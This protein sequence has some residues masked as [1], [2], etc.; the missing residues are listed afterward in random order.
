MS[1]AEPRKAKT[2]FEVEISSGGRAHDEGPSRG[3]Q[4]EQSRSLSPARAAA[5]E[6]ARR[7]NWIIALTCAGLLAAIT[8]WAWLSNP[9]SNVPPDAVARV[10]GEY[11]MERDI[12]REIGLS[13]AALY[14]AHNTGGDIPTRAKI[15]EDLITRKMQVQDARKA[16]VAVTAAEVDSSLQDVTKR[17]GSSLDKLESAL[18]NYNLTMDDMRSVTSDIV[19]TNKYINNVVVRGAANDQEVQT[20]KNDWLTQLANTS[21]IDRLKSAGAGPAPRVGAEAPDF[22]LNDLGGKPVK[23]SQLRGRPVMVNFWATW[24]PPCRAELPTI[25]QTYNETHKDPTHYEILGVATGSDPQTVQSFAKEFA[26]PF[27]VLTDHGN[28]VTDLYHVLPIPTTFFID[29]EGIIRNIQVG[30][31]DRPLLDQWLLK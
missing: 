4:G 28:S 31:V 17:T 25:V 18:N 10:N 7:R 9:N 2:P 20:K 30:M 5:K 3:A 16:G 15:L 12:D 24:C 6:R 13:K 23:L 14:L 8:S 11:I 26:M 27:P 21:K 22:T 1:K 19:L 29:K